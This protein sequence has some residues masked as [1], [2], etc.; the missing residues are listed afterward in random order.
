MKKIVMDVSKELKNHKFK[1]DEKKY[2]GYQV[3]H[4]CIDYTNEFV[5]KKKRGDYFSILFNLV[6]L[7][8]NKKGIKKE[9]IKILK[10][11]F[12]DLKTT[13]PLI[14]GLGNSSILCDSL[15][16]KSTNKIIVTNHFSDFLSLP[17]VAIFNPEVIEKTGIS[18]FN[19]IKMVV[20][21]L[22]PSVIIII[23]SLATNNIDYLNNCI[24]IHNAGIVPG[25]AIRDNKKIDENTFNIPIISIGA[26]L[27]FEYQK[28]L[29]ASSYIGEVV[30]IISSI[31]ADALND[32][33]F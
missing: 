3:N 26:P 21:S 5:A 18:S 20:C 24:E 30:D 19:L 16:V 11:F 15:G 6:S 28:E 22:K 17:K 8:K 14:I 23:D 32:L 2:S 33:F 10:Y 29:L 12:K 25:S 13:N 7:H 4:F 9:L 31:I 27:V 1:I